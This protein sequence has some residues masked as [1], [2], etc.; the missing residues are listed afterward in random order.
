M[1]NLNQYLFLSVI[2]TLL[3][4]VNG[5]Y[6]PKHDDYY[7]IYVN[8]TYGIAKENGHQKR[9]EPQQFVNS[10]ME[11][12]QQL[13]INNENTYQHPEKLEILKESNA[14]LKKRTNDLDIDYIYH[15]STI[16]DISVLSSYFSFDV[17]KKVNSIPGILGSEPKRII[18]MASSNKNVNPTETVTKEKRDID[19]NKIFNN[20]LIN[21]IKLETGWK[22]VEI[23]E[24]SDLHL[25]LLSQ[26]YYNDTGYY[27]TNYY[28]PKSAGKDIDIY[29]ID[30]SFDFR[31][32]EFSNKD[33]RTAK[34]LGVIKNGVLIKPETDDYCKYPEIYG[35]L[36]HGELV[37]DAA[38]GLKHGVA[39]KA[40]VFGLVLE[41]EITTYVGAV[42]TEHFILAFDY[43]LN[44]IPMR[45][46][47]SVINMSWVKTYP[48]VKAC[49]PDQK[50][51]FN[52]INT[53]DSLDIIDREK[54][55]VEVKNETNWKGVTFR[56][57][58]DLHL[59]LISQGKYD[60]AIH[61]NYDTTY[62]Y[63]SSAGQ[64]I[65]I[66]VIDSGFDFRHPEFSN[67]DERETKCL[68]F[69][70][71]G[72]LLKSP[73]EE[74]CYSEYIYG[75][76]GLKTSDTAAG[77]THGVASKANVYGIV[78][79]EIVS[80][81]FVVLQYIKDNRLRKNKTVFNISF[82]TYFHNEDQKE[83]IDY[84]E[85]LINSITEEGAIIVASSGNTK[86]NTH[87]ED[88]NKTFYPCSFKSVICVGAVNIF[89][90]YEGDHFPEN[91]TKIMNPKNYKK[92][93][94]SS[95]GKGIDIFAPGFSVTEYI[96]IDNNY[97][98][99]LESGTSFSSPIVAGVI[100]TL[101]SENSDTK[102]TTD[103]MRELLWELG[104]K[105]ILDEIPEGTCNI[106]I[107]NGK[108]SIY[109]GNGE[110]DSDI[111]VEV[112]IDK[113]SNVHDSDSD[114]DSEEKNGNLPIGYDN[115]IG[116][117]YPIGYYDYPTGYYDYPTGYHDYPTD[118]HD[119]PTDYHD[120]PTDYHDYPTGYHDY[121]TD[122]NYPIGD[123]Y[124][125][126]YR[127]EI[128]S[129]FFNPKR[130]KTYP[131]YYEIPTEYILRYEPHEEW[132]KD[133]YESNN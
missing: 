53:I 63:P 113:P 25:S 88:S 110:E 127:N 54:I 131:S 10:V 111:E 14:H 50:L 122:Y 19:T 78:L 41:D 123:K 119:Y 32:S 47:K 12:I 18:N 29:V 106:F 34:C 71:R 57:N 35:T 130:T 55:E 98:K 31:H 115:P 30:T 1:K 85:G 114:S 132:N 26:G 86:I 70:R 109:P 79:D 42:S 121:P 133:M 9:Q 68:Y 3:K 105:D 120:Y 49:I 107:N 81:L 95:F 72:G 46:H 39:S 21:E 23:R 77:L 62:Y 76:H 56:E 61:G 108:H 15:L 60:K 117:D 69:I 87:L 6:I 118:Y 101:M 104:E 124:P 59:S 102:Y 94:F 129:D 67:K 58:A 91:P 22:D 75:H 103:S 84:W 66:Y 52:S 17:N 93:D 4:I 100:A 40:N 73:H 89:G 43:I 99:K 90:L 74:Y 112:D 38:A 13:I 48:N 97:I 37:S 80:D 20:D 51:K 7:L 82:G 36:Q 116:Y 28:Y 96:D 24:N 128:P 126:H 44:K 5:K 83:L 27:D 45:P 65:D 125:T 2:C 16:D 64:D 8:N 11:E 92:A 33:E